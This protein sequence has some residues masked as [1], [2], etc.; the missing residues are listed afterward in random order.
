[1]NPWPRE[2][3]AP[4]LPATAEELLILHEA[5]ASLAA[6]DGTKAELVKLRFFTGLTLEEAADVLGLSLA[7]AKRAWSFAR[8][9]LFREIKRL[10]E[11]A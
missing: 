4:P 9:W 8:A 7:T 11:E 1:M 3:T 2:T 10:Q 5:L 6:P